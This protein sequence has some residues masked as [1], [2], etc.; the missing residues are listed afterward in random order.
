MGRR[1]WGWSGRGP[2]PRVGEGTRSRSPWR[3]AA[4]ALLWIT[5]WDDAASAARFEGALR[6]L[7][8]CRGASREHVGIARD[9]TRVALVRGLA[10][11][12]AEA[13]AATLV[14][15]RP[16][17]S[18]PR[19]PLGSLAPLPPVPA[20]VTAPASFSRGVQS[21]P[22]LGV[23]AAVPY[24][25]APGRD[26]DVEL[27]VSRHAPA[28]ALGA[29]EV[30]MTVPSPAGVELVFRHAVESFE[31][32]SHG[33]R[34]LEVGR[35][36]AATSLGPGV[37]RVWSVEESFL[38]LRVVVV[39]ICAR[40]G[41]LMFTQAWVDPEGRTSLDAWIASFR[42]MSPDPPPVCAEINAR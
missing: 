3:P 15:I 39:P 33:K 9:A 36:T 40:G 10:A 4:R 16:E 8:S 42:P 30:S 2:P 29:V 6:E 21:S 32:V 14:A 22:R 27:S 25:F 17:A 28:A 34:L 37:E 12:P 5:A 1:A 24:G 35:G 38:K 13:A 19:P 23:G 18:P 26:R 31:A 11:A 7:A 41:S 20:F